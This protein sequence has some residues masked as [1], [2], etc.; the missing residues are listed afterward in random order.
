L[1]G[2]IREL[3]RALVADGPI[4]LIHIEGEGN[5]VVLRVTGEPDAEELTGELIVASGFVRGRLDW[6]VSSAD[7][8]EWQEA[9]DELDA[10]YDVSWCGGGPGPEMVVVRDSDLD[11]L[12]VTI[13]DRAASSTTVDIG[14]P[15]ADSWFDEAYDRLDLVWK[16]WPGMAKA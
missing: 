9:L 3:G 7:L 12:L 10:G 13:K 14:V 8:A 2:D 16:T 6:P 5:S 11:R 4:D 1:F 15:V